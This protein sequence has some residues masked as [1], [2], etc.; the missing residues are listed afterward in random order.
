MIGKPSIVKRVYPD[1]REE[2]VRG[3]AF[4]AVP[5]RAL[6]DLLGIGNAAVPYHY[7]NAATGRSFR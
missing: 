5:Q 2:L 3:A 7:L 6:K 1:G 4:A